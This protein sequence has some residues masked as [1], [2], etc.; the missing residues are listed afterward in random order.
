[1]VSTLSNRGAVIGNHNEIDVTRAARELLDWTR[2]VRPEALPDVV[3]A[4][5]RLGEA[6]LAPVIAGLAG[7]PDV[8]V[9]VVVAQVL[10]ELAD[11]SSASI[12]ALVMLSSDDVEEVRSWATFGLGAEPLSTQPGVDDALLARLCDPCEE[13]RVEA[14]RGLARLAPN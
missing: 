12:G 7:H 3:S 5:G 2:A 6:S 8:E 9:R 11:E 4:L 14:A 13:V 1:M 10:G